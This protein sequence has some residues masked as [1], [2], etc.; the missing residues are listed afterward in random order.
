MAKISCNQFLRE[1]ISIPSSGLGTS[2]QKDGL[3][4]IPNTIMRKEPQEPPNASLYTLLANNISFISL[5]T[6]L[7]LFLLFIIFLAMKVLIRKYTL[8][9]SKTHSYCNKCNYAIAGY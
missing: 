5:A 1:S 4:N 6:S 2:R 3:P 7:V 8:A 9:D